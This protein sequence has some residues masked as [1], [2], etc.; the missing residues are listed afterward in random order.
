[1]QITGSVWRVRAVELR[2]LLEECD[3]F[4]ELVHRYVHARYVQASQCC[5]CNLMHSINE[6]LARWL[7]T[8]PLPCPGR[9]IPDHSGVSF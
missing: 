7:L 5:A 4:H 8:C 2:R 3:V 1:M 6:R 9:H